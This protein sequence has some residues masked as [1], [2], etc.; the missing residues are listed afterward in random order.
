MLTKSDVRSPAPIRVGATL[1]VSLC[2]ACEGAHAQTNV[3]QSGSAP[4][5]NGSLEQLEEVTVTGSRVITNGNQSPTPV[6]VVTSEDLAQ[7]APGSIANAL[8][9]LPAITGSKT[10]A[11]RTTGTGSPFS[12]GNPAANQL[13][14]RSL[15]LTSTLVLV[16]G[17]RV[18]PSLFTDTLDV[19]LLPELLVQR[20]D[21]VTG[22]ASA[23]YG[24]DAIGGAVNYV[25][26]HHFNG[27]KSVA[28]YGQ[29]TYSDDRTNR[30]GIAA[31]TSLFGDRV[32]VEGSY[33]HFHDS[34]LP[35]QT[36]RPDEL[37][38]GVPG[39]GTTAS[40]YTLLN[41]LRLSTHTYGGLI[42]NGP[43]NRYTFN[44]DGVITPF[45][46]GTATG[47]TN[48]QQGGD[49]VLPVFSLFAPEAYN[50]A[51][52]RVDFPVSDGIRGH[53]QA[54]YS[55]KTS[56]TNGAS[57]G[58]TPNVFSITNFTFSTANPFLSSSVQQALASTGATTFTLSKSFGLT[59]MPPQRAEAQEVQAS[60]NAGLDGKVGRF[61]WGLDL[62]YGRSVLYNNTYNTV[63]P[64]RL[65]AAL[66]AVS[67]NGQVVCNVTLTNPTANPGCV[68]LNPFGP[69]AASAASIAYISQSNWTTGVFHM[70]DAIAHVSGDLFDIWAG[71]VVGALSAEWRQVQYQS[72]VSQLST[73]NVDCTGLRFNCTA[74]TS[75]GGGLPFPLAQLTVTEPALEFAVPLAKSQRLAKDITLNLAARAVDYSTVGRYWPWKIGAEWQPVDSL[76]FRAAYSHD[77]SAPTLFE[78]FQPVPPMSVATTGSGTL[79]TLTNTSYPIANY[80]LGNPNLKAQTGTTK[81]I[82]LVW[83]PAG[84]G[85]SMSS[86]YYR[87]TIDQYILQAQG[88]QTSIQNA[89]YNSG[90]TS[91]LCQLISRP[92]YTSNVPS[93]RI[94]ATYTEF[95]NI[96]SMETWG[97][98][99]ELNYAARAF[100]HP[101]SVRLLTSYQ[102]H[103][104]LAQFGND[105]YDLG[106]AL[107]GPTPFSAH[108]SLRVNAVLRFGISDHLSFTLDERWRN[109]LNITG[110]TTGVFSGNVFVPE[111]IPSVAY[112][113]ATLDLQ[114]KRGATSFKAF[115]D[116]RNVFNRAPPPAVLNF[117]QLG[118]GFGVA[119]GDDPI[120]RYY[121]VGLRVGL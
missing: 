66:D 13:N 63:N 68:P 77:I 12:G 27:V 29:S 109:A 75:L 33:E 98:D 102:P 34:G 10:Q 95:F 17:H 37:G 5:R 6:T 32:H 56:Y 11:S 31:G 70:Y 15:G 91:P 55:D 79:D 88:F 117:N 52:G 72:W 101:Y 74:G 94:T 111:Q 106:D 50:K 30:I 3:P 44:S 119:A 47:T 16:D 90:G 24:S 103:L 49:G 121:T 59:E 2:L 60:F 105:V 20:V 113:D 62:N 4:A 73:Q 35:Y 57:A 96:A 92:S 76:R 48:V 85:F 25:L 22:G 41:N 18:V 8:N 58:N 21:V 83:Q 53:A 14:L 100:D 38:W 99:L 104:I 23:V 115:F 110:N 45:V 40:P 26:D 46:N 19:D 9:Q 114:F 28:Q 107:N 61:D 82:G 69:T 78:L 7:L 43:R 86:D 65:S 108:P 36:M 54:W 42:T 1:A 67:S 81:T 89:C 39:A 80:N 97:D 118:P 87:I 71:P 120:G 116:V 84:S 51:F 64:Q 93:N 112:T